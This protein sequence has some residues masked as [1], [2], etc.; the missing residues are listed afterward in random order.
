MTIY[1]TKEQ[2]LAKPAEERGYNMIG[3]RNVATL[4]RYI[5][6]AGAV[7]CPVTFIKPVGQPG[8]GEPEEDQSIPGLVQE[9]AYNAFVVLDQWGRYVIHTLENKAMVMCEHCGNHRPVDSFKSDDDLQAWFR[10][11][12][13]NPMNASGNVR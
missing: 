5:V 2:Y 8:G 10:D 4:R 9:P 3:A 1:L 12:V 7:F 11:C 13:S 6:G